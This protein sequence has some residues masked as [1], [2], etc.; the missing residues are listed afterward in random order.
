MARIKALRWTV[1]TGLPPEIGASLSPAESDFFKAY[2]KCAPAR[3][4]HALCACAC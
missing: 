3:S 4:A 2:S 1:G